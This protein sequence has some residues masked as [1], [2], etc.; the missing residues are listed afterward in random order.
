[1]EADGQADVHSRGERLKAIEDAGEFLGLRK[2]APL[3]LSGAIILLFVTLFAVSASKPLQLDNMDFP[4]VAEQT[5]HT[6]LPIHYRGEANPRVAGLYHPPLYIYLLAGW[7]R[8]FGSEPAAV[9]LFGM[10]C[11]LLQGW[12]ALAIFST[13]FGREAAFARAPLFWTI[14]LLNPY[15]LQTAGIADIDS[16]IYGPLL[17]L[18]LLAVLRI[19]WRHGEWRPD[20]AHGYEY[21]LVGLALTLCLWAKLTTVLLLFPFVF[22]LL[23]ARLGTVRAALTTIA[24]VA[25]SVSAF[26]GSYYLY[27]AL[28]GL[29]VNYTFAFTW[30]SF[31]QRGSSGTPGI[32]ARID[33]MRRNL[34][35]MGPFMV[36][37]TGS[38]PWVAAS[39]AASVAAVGALRRRDLRLAHYALVLSLA[40]L[41]TFYYCAKVST[42]G[43]A[44]FKYTLVVWGLILTAPVFLLPERISLLWTIVVAAL[45]VA[46]SLGSTLL[47][48]DKLI[49]EGLS[50]VARWAAYLPGLLFAAAFILKRPLAAKGALAVLAIYA[51]IQFGIGVYQEKVPYATTYDYGQTGFTETVGF[52]DENT[53]PGQVIVSM[54]DIGYR[55]RR[56]YFENYAALYGDP[57]SAAEIE[58]AIASGQAAYAVF[59]EGRGQ[60]Q[61][62]MNPALRRWVAEHCKLVRSFGNYRIYQLADAPP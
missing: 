28:S 52:I 44:P 59:T 10:V 12:V 18:V 55:S 5:A 29:D 1:M 47:M 15:T 60:D 31:V 37:W 23:I 45:F 16:T 56:R 8:V 22:L 6:G 58:A 51:G 3:Y 36:C 32:L 54:K 42:F 39:L 21:A 62:V 24:L 2:L 41:C 61:L 34:C 49:L 7:M 4:A 50:G 46:A 53:Q 48:G 43:Q 11:A 20:G 17:C 38:L 30:M 19:S 40:L 14:F 27:G 13:L 33:D 25:A 57:A 35:A 26:L 9:R